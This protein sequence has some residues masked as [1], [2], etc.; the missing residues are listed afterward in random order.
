M[1]VNNGNSVTAPGDSDPQVPAVVDGSGVTAGSNVVGPLRSSSNDRDG[2]GVAK[3][4]PATLAITSAGKL[5]EETKGNEDTSVR[6][7]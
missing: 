5:K 3:Q 4:A 1:K 7:N 2:A 6:P